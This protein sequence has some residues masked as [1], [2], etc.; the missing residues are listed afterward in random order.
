LRAI[1]T[2][3]KTKKTVK[4]R[5]MGDNYNERVQRLFERV[6]NLQSAVDEEKSTRLK[7]IETVLVE[8]ERKLNSMKDNKNEK[9][10]LFEKMVSVQLTFSLKTQYLLI[11]D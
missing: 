2:F 6:G 11:I 7:E 9:I 3:L 8:L 4:K 10:D 5:K 1:K